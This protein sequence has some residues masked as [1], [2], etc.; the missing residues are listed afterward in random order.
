MRHYMLTCTALVALATASVAFGQAPASAP[1][2]EASNPADI[3]VT[4][5][6][7]TER[8]NDI[9]VAASVLSA[10]ALENQH[11]QDISDI[12]KVVPSVE[13]KGT[14]N[15]RV[16]YSIRGISTNAN[17]GAIGL[18][19]GVSVQIDGIPVPADS[20]AAN[21][22]SGISQLEVLKGP[23]ATLGG[24]TAS[25]GVINFV[26]NSPTKTLKGNMAGGVTDD[27]EYRVEANISGPV[28]NAVSFSLSG[29][30]SH[31]PYPVYNLQSN[32]QSNADSYG[33]R[34]KLK[35]DMGSNFDATIMGHYALSTSAGENFI[36]QYITPGAFLIAPPLT[37]ALV[38]GNYTVKYGNT[39]YSS[40]VAMSSR[41]EDSDASLVLNYHFSDLTL[42]STTS[43][44]KENQFQSQDLFETQIY[45]FNVLTGGFA[46]PFNDQ[47]SN[48]GYVKQTTQEFKIASDN[49]KPFSFLA[50]AF[51]S[52][53]EVN[54]YG[55][56]QFVGFPA[57]QT[58]VSTTQNYAVYGRV[59]NKF[60]DKI[61]LNA[62][63][64]YN[65]DKIGWN[66]TQ[67]FNPA[68]GQY[69]SGNFGDGG[70]AW[71]QSSSNGTLVGDASLQYHMDR[72]SMAYASYTRGYKP[73][74]YNTAHT[75][76]EAPTPQTAP[77]AANFGTPAAYATALASYN[78]YLAD[79]SFTT[80]T[81]GETIDSFELGLKTS[82]MNHHL[83]FNADIFYTN[84]QNYQAQ[85]FDNSKLIGILVLANAGARTQGVEMD[86]TWRQGNTNLSLSGAYIDAIF[87]NFPST[88]CYPTQTVAAGCV[89]GAQSLSGHSLPDSPKFKF[90]ANV[91]QT[92]PLSNFNILLGSN[93]SYRTSA[94]L[95][96]DG[97]PQTA[98]DAF[99][100]LD[101][102]IGF[103]TKDK[104]A[105]LTLYVNNIANHFYLTNAEDFFSGPWGANAVIGQP[106]RDSHRYFGARASLKF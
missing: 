56:R 59:T 27:G 13:I 94:V 71:N 47:Q 76:N 7:R 37:Q 105:A 22:L 20:F 4:A 81:K 92:I 25:A 100:I 28:A 42:S 24:R 19:S 29:Y 26:T 23:Q 30:D 50:G 40:P 84:Y 38:L 46:P 66:L 48:Q 65:Y 83:S 3:V 32:A 64:R 57:S 74:A 73:A 80:P 15:G 16:P 98:Q 62:G 33:V 1:A 102:S 97:N 55:L 68:M 52:D 12:N 104:H 86:A 70:Y 90:N 6:K 43:Y 60:S 85:I 54:G 2:V 35:F 79:V 78:Q 49:R 67:Y 14:F 51:Y 87:K 82:A 17:E 99:G 91:E 39:S 63:L 69:G 101:A 95:Q 88:Q 8:L 72:D 103:Q 34:A 10:K 53:M 96:S 9:P 106:A 11:V 77:V 75:F 18:T 58:N 41:Y 5:Q 45:F 31:T 36:Y 21:T 93:F 44:F 89:N 61:S